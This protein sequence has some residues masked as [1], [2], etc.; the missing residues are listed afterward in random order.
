MAAFTFGYTMSKKYAV[1]DCNIPIVRWLNIIAL[2]E[3][4]ITAWTIIELIVVC[5]VADPVKARSRMEIVTCCL[6]LNFAIAWCSYGNAW[7]Y[8]DEATRCRNLSYDAW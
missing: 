3:I 1:E 8:T 7:I 5:K 2:N 6:F 4:A